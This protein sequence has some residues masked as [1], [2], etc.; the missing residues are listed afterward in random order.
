MSNAIS[1]GMLS[2]HNKTVVIDTKG[3]SGKVEQ[4]SLTPNKILLYF[5]ETV[6]F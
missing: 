3:E 1:T 5:Y 6:K 2:T 4:I